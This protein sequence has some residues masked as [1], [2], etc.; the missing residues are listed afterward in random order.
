M[1]APWLSVLMP[2]YNGAAYLRSALGSVLRQ[3]DKEIECIA[4]DDGSTDETLAILDSYRTR[5]NLTVIE[6]PRVGNWVANTNLALERASGRFACF[7]HQDDWWLDGR[8]EALRALIHRHRDVELFLHPVRFI[9]RRGRDLGPWR[10]PLPPEPRV[11]RP[12][13]ILPRLIVQNFVAIPAPVRQNLGILEKYR[14]PM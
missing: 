9:D 4:V 5:L 13:D 6:R 8:L 1:S 12:G 14:A 3:A 7:L 2:T 10:C 11:M